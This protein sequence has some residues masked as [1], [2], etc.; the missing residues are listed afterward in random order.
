MQTA[1][2]SIPLLLA[3]IQGH[4]RQLVARLDVSRG[5]ISQAGVRDVGHAKRE[6]DSPAGGAIRQKRHYAVGVCYAGDGLTE[7]SRKCAKNIGVGDRGAAVVLD[8]DG[9]LAALL[10]LP[11]GGRSH[12]D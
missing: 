11:G 7:R 9:R 12:H 8:G 1:I 6:A 5:I 3:P 2:K 4:K 10:A